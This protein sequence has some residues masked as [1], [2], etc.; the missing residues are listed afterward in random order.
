MTDIMGVF[1][2]WL[3]VERKS[4][5]IGRAA[6]NSSL[7][8]SELF[9]RHLEFVLCFFP[10]GDFLADDVWC[11]NICFLDPRRPY[12]YCR[13]TFPLPSECSSGGGL[14]LVLI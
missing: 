6:F 12:T 2:S 9:Q 8:V 5:F 11:P 14:S 1:S 13:R 7:A 4:S 3:T 10:L